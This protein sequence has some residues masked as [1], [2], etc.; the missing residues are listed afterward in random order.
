MRSFSER[1]F[2][3]VFFAGGSLFGLIFR[4]LWLV[5]SFAFKG[6]LALGDVKG[7]PRGNH[8]SWV[9]LADGG[10]FYGH[11]SVFGSC[12][13]SF[14]PLWGFGALGCV[15]VKHASVSL[16]STLFWALLTK[17]AISRSIFS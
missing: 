10:S 12:Q 11:V 14:L 4:F 8:P 2:L 5:E 6:T 3:A 15:R 16:E 7:R 9:I 13:G 17:G 1:F